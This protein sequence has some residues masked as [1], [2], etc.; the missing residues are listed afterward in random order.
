MNP[1]PNH[2]I[3]PVMRLSKAI[4][5]LKSTL[6]ASNDAFDQLYT[7]VHE[8]K[9]QQEDRHRHQASSSQT[10]DQEA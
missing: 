2:Q 9:K 4:D 10:S 1:R 7:L 6:E 8:L 5:N 3:R